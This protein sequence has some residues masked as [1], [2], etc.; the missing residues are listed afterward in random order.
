MEFRDLPPKFQENLSVYLNVIIQIRGQAH[1]C[2]HVNPVIKYFLSI[3]S[4]SK[5]KKKSKA[6]TVL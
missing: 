5:K 3:T 4:K 1:A 6:V 2:M